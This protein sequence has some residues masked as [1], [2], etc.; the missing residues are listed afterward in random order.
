[1]RSHLAI[2]AVFLAF[3][4]ALPACAAPEGAPASAV[5]SA[6]TRPEASLENRGAFFAKKLYKPQP[7]PTFAG[8]KD[9]LPSPI[10]DERPEYVDCYW[11]AWRMAFD[12]F[13]RPMPGSPFV[14]NYID[15]NFNNS[16]FLWD[17]AFMTMFCNYAH[18]YVP[19]IV[20]LD[21]F[22][23]TQ[24]SDGEIVREVS[25]ADGKPH[26]MSKPG[27]P[28]SLNHPILAWAERESFHISGDVDRLRLVYQPL[29]HY[30]RSYAKIKDAGSGFYLTTWAAMDNSPR[31]E[32]MLCGI[33]TTAEVALFARDLAAIARAIGRDDEAEK[34]EQEAM[35]LGE[36]INAELWDDT[37]GFYYD[38]GTT[39]RRHNVRT[40]AAFW[41][42][43]A[44]ITR[45]AQVERLV[46]HLEDPQAFN[47]LHRVPTVPAD[48]IGYHGDGH[49]WRG[50][51]WTPTNT[52]IIRGLER[53]GRPE[54][55]RTIALNHLENVVRVWQQTGTIWEFYA[56]DATKPGALPGHDTRKEFVGWSGI[57]P[58][59]YLIEHAIGIHVDAP[60]N[61]IHWHI[62]SPKQ[63][64]VER[65]W[66]G[67]RTVS[68]VCEPDSGNGQRVVR[69]RAN[70]A[71]RLTIRWRAS[72]H[73]VNIPTD[74]DVELRIGP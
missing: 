72:E 45:P 3:V 1:M 58:I 8:T 40:I 37:T 67:G 14:S 43:L 32:G 46:E 73:T 30:Y 48:E 15:E 13:R 26:K 65:L 24:L 38:W 31:I 64:G 27:T 11:A 59:V 42:M 71:F 28:D 9:R 62:Q 61:Q 18:P 2:R 74:Q 34:W 21:N 29:V 5:R 63:V 54:L 10:F 39:G 17:T 55:A 60:G 16:I 7:L 25:E 56:P 20:S 49:Y 6:T 35:H 23:C 12:R 52:M 57:G 19:G 66:F 33:D 44:G 69:V 53:S 4:P 41:P 22:Y 68:L 70:G 51:V 50:G 36:R 47:R